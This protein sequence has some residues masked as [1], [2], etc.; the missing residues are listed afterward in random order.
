[1]KEFFMILRETAKIV[2]YG[3]IFKQRKMR[4]CTEMQIDKKMFFTQII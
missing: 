3:I 1:M 2:I 4:W